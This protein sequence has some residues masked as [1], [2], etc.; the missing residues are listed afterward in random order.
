MNAVESFISLGLNA[1]DS[2]ES[3]IALF[4]VPSASAPVTAIGLEFTLTATPLHFSIDEY[5]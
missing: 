2:N 1:N 5:P 4:L 3:F